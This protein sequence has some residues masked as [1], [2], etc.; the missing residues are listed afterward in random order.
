MGRNA[1][2]AALRNTGL[3]GWTSVGCRFG[4]RASRFVRDGEEC[5]AWLRTGEGWALDWGVMLD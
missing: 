2:L 4:P 5:R 3:G 1:L